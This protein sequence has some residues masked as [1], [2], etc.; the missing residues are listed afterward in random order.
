MDGKPWSVGKSK[1]LP[2]SLGGWPIGIAEVGDRADIILTEGEGDFLAAISLHCQF[3]PD[4]KT[5]APRDP[6]TFGF[7]CLTGGAKKIADSALP[8]FKGKTVRIVPHVD[9]AGADAVDTWGRQLIE[10]GA[11]V[12]VFDLAGMLTDDGKPA[13]DLNDV[14][15]QKGFATYSQQLSDLFS[16]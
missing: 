16:P 8:L 12:R 1:S 7:C 4:P 2:G 6:G 3:N 10:A 5:H 15:T 11:K 13:K 14:S 9:A